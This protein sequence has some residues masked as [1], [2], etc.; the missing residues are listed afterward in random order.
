M[1]T[2]MNFNFN[3][4]HKAEVGAVA[5]ADQYALLRNA[6]PM[7]NYPNPITANLLAVHLYL[8][9]NNYDKACNSQLSS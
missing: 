4:N 6:P 2:R 9:V 3:S 7:Q 5:K 1:S 8:R